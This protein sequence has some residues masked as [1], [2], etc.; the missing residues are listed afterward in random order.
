MAVITFPSSPSLYQ[1]FTVGSKTWI[2]NGYAWDL[3]SGNTSNFLAN[4][5]SQ[6][7][8]NSNSVVY[9]ANTTASASNTTGALIVNGGA[10]IKGNVYSDKIY[11]NG[12]YYAANGNPIQTG[13]SGTDAAARAL[14]QGAF[15]EANS[16]YSLASS[17]SSTA[18]AAYTTACNAI[19]LAQSAYNQANTGGGG[20]PYIIT[21]ANYVDYGWVYQ[22][23]GPVQFNYGTL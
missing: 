7:T 20:G 23:A 2:W 18:G 3:Q 13:G 6:I 21:G 17:A 1:T 14:A 11:T 12:L 9:V 15:D 5:G 10:G 4:T 16:A 19:V 8:L 22:T